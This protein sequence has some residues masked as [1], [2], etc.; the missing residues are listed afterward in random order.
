MLIC[1]NCLTVNQDPANVW[2]CLCGMV[3]SEKNTLEEQHLES[4][5]GWTRPPQRNAWHVVHQYLSNRWNEW[6]HGQK[7]DANAAQQWYR[8]V[9]IP[10][11]PTGCNCSAHWLDITQEV[12]IDWSSPESAF[13]SFWHLHNLVSVRK[14]NKPTIELLEAQGLFRCPVNRGRRA[15][16]T[17][18][19]GGEHL[20]LLASTRP[21]LAAYADRCGADY[22]EITNDLRPDWPMANKYRMTS[23]AWHYDQSLLIDCDV[24]IRPGAP[25]IFNAAGD[26]MLAMRDERP[27]YEDDWFRNESRQFY[28]SQG[29]EF[30]IDRCGNAGVMVFRPEAL[31]A[32]SEPSKPYPKF[33][34]N[35]QFWLYYQTRNMPIRWLD[36]RFN[37]GSIRKD[38]AAGIQDA[39]FIHL[40]GMPHSARMEF[41]NNFSR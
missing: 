13:Q 1:P 33:W 16:I 32:Y 29:V 18:A 5:V 2:V 28:A 11:I 27:D 22:Y 6:K 8:D 17:C 41:I 12:K 4:G 20:E 35:E 15:V 21:L 7:W 36:D 24:L 38:F 25:D 37:W 10:Q 34:C 9:W 39:W 19:T 30:E 23:Y 40:N 26:S 3:V 14:S 31:D